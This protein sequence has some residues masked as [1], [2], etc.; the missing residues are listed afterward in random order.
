MLDLLECEADP[1]TFCVASMLL[2][3]DRRRAGGGGGGET[4]GVCDEDR[5]RFKPGGI[6]MSN[7][8]LS[9]VGPCA[10]PDESGILT[11]LPVLL[12]GGGRGAGFCDE[13][14]SDMLGG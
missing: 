1:S 13:M 6:L 4:R 11:A 9:F 3:L 14:L 12:A 5:F 8:V 2:L 10:A 7:D